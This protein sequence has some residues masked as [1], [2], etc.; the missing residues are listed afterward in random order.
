MSRYET[1]IPRTSFGLAAIGLTVATFAL[2]VALPAS[3]YSGRIND[4]SAALAKSAAQKPIEVAIIPSRIVVTGQCD[5]AMA[6]EPPRRVHTV[7]R[8]S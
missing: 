1:S 7:D 6:Y 4:A 5:Q 8:E 3:F 2:T